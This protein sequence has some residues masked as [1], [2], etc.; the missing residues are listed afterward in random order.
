MSIA[1]YLAKL[2]EGVN[3]SG[4]LATS[5]GGTG[6]TSGGAF[7]TITGISYGGDGN[8]T[9]TDTAGGRTVTITGA[10]FAANAKVLINGVAAPVVTVV[11]AS[12]ITFTTPAMAAG[13]YVL[14]VVNADGSTAI[15]VPGISYSGVPTWSTAAGTVATVIETAAINASLSVTSNSTTSISLLSGSLPPGAVLNSNG[16]IS[17][18]SQLTASPTT[19]TFTLRATD[20]ELQDTDRQ[21]SIVINPETI[22]W[23]NPTSGGTVNAYTVIPNTINISAIG[24][25]GNAVSSFSADTLP[26]GL[27]LSGNTI[28]GIATNTGTSSTTLTGTTSTTGRTSQ[29]T[30]NWTVVVGGDTYWKNVSLML[31]GTALA[32]NFATDYSLNNFQPLIVGDTRPTKFSPYQA[33]YYSTYYDGTG[34]YLTAASNAGLGF[35]TG[36]FTVEGWFNFSGAVAVS[37]YQRPWWFG[38]DNDNVEL[39]TGVLKV[40]GATQGTLIT[41]ATAIKKNTWYHIALTRQSG[42]YKLWLNGA[43][44]G[45]SATNSYSS[46]AR[47]F[48]LMSTSAAANPSSGFVSNVRVV[49]GTALYTAAFTPSTTPLTA[50]TNTQLLISQANR[51]IDTSTNAIALT[52]GGDTTVTQ[53]VPFTPPTNSYGSTYFDGT[54]DYLQVANNASISNLNGSNFTVECWAYATSTAANICLMAC[55]SNPT[56]S[57]F[58]IFI[59]SGNLTVYVNTGGTTIGSVAFPINAWNHVA[60][61]RNG[62]SCTL[63]LNGVSIASAT[64]DVTNPAT[65][66]PLVI[67]GITTTTG[68]N[69]NL[70][71]TGYIADARIVKG[72][73]VYTAAFTPP[74]APLTAVTNTTLLTCQTAQPSNNSQFMDNSG[75]S[76][77]MTRSGNVAQG[78]FSPYGSNWSTY[79]SGSPDYL[80]ITDNTNIQPGTGDFTVELW[81]FPTGL[82]GGTICNKG[83]GFQLYTNGSQVN[84]V[85]VAYSV[86]NASPYFI[87]AYATAT[88]VDYSWNHIAATRSGNNYY[89]YINGAQ[90]LVGTSSSSPDTGTDAFFLGSFKGLSSFINGYISNF[91]FVKGTAVYT[92]AFTPPTAPLTAVNGT[93]VLLCQDNRFIDNGPNTLPVVLSGAPKVQRFSPFGNVIQTPIT[94]SNYFDGSGDYITVNYATGSTIAGDFTWETWVY[95]T[96]VTTNGTLLGWRTGSTGWTGI[97]VQRNTSASNLVVSINNGTSITQTSGTYLMRQWN[98]VALVRSGTTV[99]L[100]VNGTSA[101]TATVSGSFN[102]GTSYWIGSDP[103]NNVAAVQIQGSISNQRFVNGTAIYTANFT[104]PTSPL[105]AVTNTALLTCQSATIVDNSTNAFA[106]TTAGDT[107]ARIFNP[108]G[109]TYNTG[110]GYTPAL[111]GGS[112]YF[113]G[114]GDYLTLPASS[115]P[116]YIGSGDFTV[117]AWVYKTSTAALGTVLSYGGSYF[118]IFVDNITPVLWIGATQTTTGATISLNT[119]NHIVLQRTGTVLRFYVNGIAATSVTNSTDFTL[120]TMTIGSEGAGSYFPGYI[121][122]VRITQ[123]ALYPQSNFVPPQV[124]FTATKNTTLLLSS[125]KT[126]I[127]DYAKGSNLETVGDAKIAPQSAYEGNYYSNYF[128]GTG[129][130]LTTSGTYT[131]GTSSFTIEGW[132]NPGAYPGSLY[133]AIFGNITTVTGNTQLILTVNPSGNIVFM[134][135]GVV[136]LTTSSTVPLGQWSHVALS[137]DGTTYRVYINGV[138]GA[139]GTTLYNF[140]TAGPGNVGYAGLSGISSFTGYI[141]NLRIV[142]GT[143]LYTTAFT[144]ATTP[145]TA[146]TGTSLLT[147]QS[148]KFVDNSS[149]AYTIT[150]SGDT[151]VKSINPFRRNTNTSMY[152]DGT[153]DNLSIPVNPIFGFGTGDFTVEFWMNLNSLLT[154]E[155]GV[156]ESQTT[157]A[158]CI[159]KVTTSGV[160]AWRPYGGTDQTILAHASIPI[161]QWTHIAISRSSGV[162]K[163]FVNGT[164]TNSVA[165][166]NNYAIPTVVYTVGG[167]NGGTNTV[168]GYIEDLR[169]TKGYARY[170]ANFTPTTAKLPTK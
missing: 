82:S 98:H 52:K 110:Q 43:Q 55:T 58:A 169:I 78:T 86:N 102:P 148:N 59:L 114:T 141:S 107:K 70:Y 106:L 63:Y 26:A 19:Y 30:F 118:R 66:Q 47:T 129:D 131:F 124:P 153:G 115:V 127:V 8:D 123:Q 142:Q 69:S 91:R 108:F 65:T 71:L 21:F 3:S 152:F 61:V 40:G 132:I 6:T 23:S 11:S 159:Y 35:A 38:D 119:W 34:D 75:L 17:G 42:V 92:A 48:T 45:S 109:F 14:Y 74:T 130:W 144:P 136:I 20:A 168:P 157:N 134:T 24:S 81:W 29:I 97:L 5:K 161:G 49:K 64:V 16:T 155:M 2:S 151:A 57:G 111:Y 165:D 76:S 83:L 89:I 162:T 103:Y 56:A 163:A 87:S 4:I 95:D 53:F 145:L 117:E 41:G 140:S 135:W 36:D 96:G 84:Q 143:A 125:D 10:N 139:S 137:F 27:T 101:G 1:A 138:L 88:L 149:N 105:T 62:T 94:Y 85:G 7:P 150:R 25:A 51:L 12:N 15:A 122:D 60:F 128:D 133:A 13:T 154:T 112:A 100:Y 90:T 28:S 156:L 167:R 146:V 33:G 72:T 170:T 79:I 44:E 39:N 73:A 68:W 22:V 121:S 99:T 93:G 160:L 54:G 113:D 50:V 77:I 166:T 126:G 67:G 18:T 116:L 120:G 46:A 104:P 164:Q 147:C 158:F 37:T 9:A 31:P 80:S 32:D